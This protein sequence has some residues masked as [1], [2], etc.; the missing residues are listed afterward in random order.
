MVLLKLSVAQRREAVTA[1][2]SAAGTLGSEANE[3]AAEALEITFAS[4]KGDGAFPRPRTPAR[5]A[6]H[7]LGAL[8]V[9][10][11]SPVCCAPAPGLGFCIAGGLE[12]LSKLSV[13]ERRAA[14]TAA[15]SAAGTLGSEAKERAAQALGLLD[16]S[17]KADIVG[18]CTAGGLAVLEPLSMQDRLAAVK[19]ARRKS[20]AAG[21]KALTAFKEVFDFNC[22]VVDLNSGNRVC[23][24]A[25]YC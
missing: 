16:A 13:A 14:V 10:L 7:Q 5:P 12:V 20:S 1:A 25:L 21:N 8:L 3:R 17:G 15:R 4:G 6:T 2:R 24:C 18:F 9:C 22:D 19:K 11:Q 23:V